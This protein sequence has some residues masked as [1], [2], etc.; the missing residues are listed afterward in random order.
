MRTHVRDEERV[1]PRALLTPAVSLPAAPG[2]EMLAER[3]AWKVAEVVVLCERMEDRSET[4]V[5][6]EGGRERGGAGY[7]YGGVTTTVAEGGGEARRVLV[8][9]RE[10][11][12]SGGVH[13]R[14]A[15][16][17]LG[18]IREDRALRR[19]CPRN[20][21]AGTQDTG[22]AG[23]MRRGRRWRWRLLFCYGKRGLSRWWWILGTRREGEEGGGSGDVFEGLV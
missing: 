8:R 21:E 20:F 23:W 7:G 3:D 18:A 4:E 9:E 10:E 12:L 14:T 6:A 19:N 15:E 11:L 2:L 13:V 1:V 22:A 16:V 5:R 17:T